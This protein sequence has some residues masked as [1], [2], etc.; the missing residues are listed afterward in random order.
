MTEP[1]SNP[2]TYTFLDQE[3]KR[4]GSTRLLSAWLHQCKLISWILVGFDCQI[5]DDFDV[6]VMAF[7]EGDF[8]WGPDV[9]VIDL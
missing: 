2:V 5:V 4:S 8:D 1:H 6:S 7:S 3:A 9:H